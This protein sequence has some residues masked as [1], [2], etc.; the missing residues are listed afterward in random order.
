MAAAMATEQVLAL[1]TGRGEPA[2]EPPA[3]A[4]T[5]ELDPLHGRLLRRRWPT[6]PD[7]DCGAAEVPGRA[8]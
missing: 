8:S 4:T 5:F 7:C 1:L 3:T 6:H 2:Q